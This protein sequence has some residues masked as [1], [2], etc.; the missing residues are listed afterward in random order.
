MYFLRIILKIN[1]IKKLFL[2]KSLFLM[3]FL[4]KKTGAFLETP[5]TMICTPA[6]MNLA[7]LQAGCYSPHP[8]V[9]YSTNID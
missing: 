6:L 5:D 3:E 4:T 2:L 1:A 7:L 8:C 9:Q